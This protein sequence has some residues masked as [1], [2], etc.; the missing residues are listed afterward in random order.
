MQARRELARGVDPILA[1]RVTGQPLVLARVGG[2]DRRREP[3]GRA[4]LQH[5]RV[6]RDRVERVGVDH[7]RD[8]GLGDDPPNRSLCA[9]LAAQSGTDRERAEARQVFQHLVGRV[10]LERAVA[11][12]RQGP[13][14]ELAS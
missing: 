12:R 6:H 7:E 8:V 5:R 14:D 2:Q 1:D 9:R 3:C 10:L 4:R 11:G 13:G